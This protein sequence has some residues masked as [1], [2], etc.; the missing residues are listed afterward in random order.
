MT[1]PVRPIQDNVF[2]ALEPYRKETESGIEVVRSRETQKRGV[3]AA[4]VLA[5]GPGYRM[6]SGVFVPNVVKVGDRVL[7][8]ALAGQDWSLDFDA[9]RSN[10]DAQHPDASTF[11]AL[12]GHSDV[13]CVREDEILTCVSD[14]AVLG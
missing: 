6:K 10:T 4:R 3:R 2:I 1:F 13:R 5:T 7:V 8:S 12:G 11:P 9:P 14:D